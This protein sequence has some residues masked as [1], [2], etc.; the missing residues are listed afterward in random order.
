MPLFPGT[1][2][3]RLTPSTTGR[4]IV[5]GM[6][7]TVGGLDPSLHDNANW[8]SWSFQRFPVQW[9]NTLWS[10]MDPM[11]ESESWNFYSTMPSSFNMGI[12]QNDPDNAENYQGGIA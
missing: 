3:I 7:G 1:R 5:P 6:L 11:E 8:N 2:V 4:Q 9:D 12:P 10:S